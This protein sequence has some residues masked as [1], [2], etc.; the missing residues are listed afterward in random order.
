M[1][2]LIRTELSKKNKY[3]IPKYRRLELKNFCLQ[4]KEW[5][6]EYL[7]LNG[8]SGIDMF[9]PTSEIAIRRLELKTKMDMVKQCAQECDVYLGGFIFNSV[10]TGRTYNYYCTA[11]GMACG[12]DMF[13]DRLHKFFYILDKRRK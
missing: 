2:T 1:S 6:T 4:Y 5:E 11:K 8:Y 10:I 9:D 3:Y 13:Y 7:N 12:K